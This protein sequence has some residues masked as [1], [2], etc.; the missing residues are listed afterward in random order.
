MRDLEGLISVI[1][2]FEGS[3][4]LWYMTDGHVSKEAFKAECAIEFEQDFATEDIQHAYARNVPA[5]RGMKQTLLYLADGPGYGAFPVTY[6][7]LTEPHCEEQ[8]C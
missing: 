6:V 2:E 1:H 4:P 7:D 5:G 3:S 8:K